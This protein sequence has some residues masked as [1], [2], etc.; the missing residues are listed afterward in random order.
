MACSKY[1]SIRC[2]EPRGAR[3]LLEVPSR[4]T[5]AQG[6]DSFWL[7]GVCS[8]IS[9]RTEGDVM[10]LDKTIAR[11]RHNVH[12]RLSLMHTG[13]IAEHWKQTTTD[14]RVVLLT[15]SRLPGRATAMEFVVWSGDVSSNCLG[16][17]APDFAGLNFRSQR[18]SVLGLQ[19]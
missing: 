8:L 5:L 9:A 4:A 6:W 11:Q 16:I 3:V 7:D 18:I 12:Q 2:N 19:T 14:K 13:G 1:A 10:L 15:R 17:P